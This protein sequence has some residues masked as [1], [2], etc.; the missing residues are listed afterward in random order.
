MTHRLGITD[1]QG[2][3]FAI[4]NGK[5]RNR[6]PIA[7]KIAF[8]TAGAI[9]G[10]PLSPAPPMAAPELTI[11]AVVDD[12]ADG[13]CARLSAGTRHP[14]AADQPVTTCLAIAPAWEPAS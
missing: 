12:C 5:E 8:A 2:Y 9:A 10:V 6:I 7:A 14:A 3:V 13:G 11:S 1:T 4:V